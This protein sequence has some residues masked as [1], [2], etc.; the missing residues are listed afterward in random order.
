MQ[1]SRS[2]AANVVYW[3]E[4]TKALTHHNLPVLDRDRQNLYRAIR[5]GLQL[6]DTWQETAVLI[7][8]S[9]PLIEKRGYWG[10]WIPIME[11]AL[12]KCPAD[13]VA[14]RGRL[15]DCLGVFYR[16]N[17][18][19][20][21]AYI[22]HQEELLL[23]ETTQDNWRIAHAGINLAAVCRHMRRFDEAGKYI[24]RAQNAFQA[25]N[26]PLVKHAFV[27][28]EYGL[29]AQA[30][31]QWPMAEEHLYA[32]VSL[33]REI[34][35][36]VNLANGLMLL[37][38]VLAAQDKIDDALKTYHEALDK[39]DA[40]ENYLDQSK[41]LNVLGI[42]HYNQGDF[43]EALRQLLA[44]DSVYLR[45]SGNLFDQAIV[46]TNLGNVYQV[47]G[48]LKEAEHAFRRS[49]M[50]W[51]TCG[52]Q[53]QLANSLISLA[54]V[55]IEQGDVVEAQK[56]GWRGGELLAGYP[57]DVWAQKLQKRLVDLMMWQSLPK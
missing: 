28:L 50:F 41:I 1:F 10:E 25:I 54:E 13:N 42:L 57:D 48:K 45:Q 5:F 33:W 36:P 19:L 4:R 23:G 7:L 9:F 44:A 38:Q 14:L 53:L 47:Q 21:K 8:Q 18:Q 24:L 52:D 29:Q 15:L 51:E 27:A 35:D 55:K 17:R 56:L 40:T 11:R 37:G 34:G 39:L 43:D 20:D 32:S 16:Y 22:I 30:Q 46:T 2:V 31:E 6:A 12:D 49:M 26:A 3:Q